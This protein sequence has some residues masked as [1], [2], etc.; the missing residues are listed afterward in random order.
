M[1]IKVLTLGLIC[2]FMLGSVLSAEKKRQIK[3]SWQ[4]FFPDHLERVYLIMKDG[5]IFPYTS[6]YDGKVYISIGWFEEA[7][8]KYK[9]KNYSIK[10][11]AVV[12]H[13]HQ[14]NKN[15]GQE[16]YKQY[17]MLKRYGFD[18]QFLLYCHRT[19]EVYDIEGKSK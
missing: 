17:G 6:H 13:N 18:G 4:E 3:I 1:R 10:D 12:I 14:K 7:L 16:D 11:I 8:R 5:T 9:N 19:K 2:L 15:F